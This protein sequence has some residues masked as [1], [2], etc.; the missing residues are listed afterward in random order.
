MPEQTPSPRPG[1]GCEPGQPQAQPDA[2]TVKRL[3]TWTTQYFTTAGLATPRLDAEVLLAHVLRR[4]RLAL[5]LDYDAPVPEDARRAYRALI[6]RRRESEPVAY[7]TGTR[8]FFSLPFVVNRSVLIPRPE[9]EHLVELAL[10]FLRRPYT[11]ESPT[12]QRI[13]EIGTG[14]GNIALTLAHHLPEAWVVSVDICPEA[15]AVARRNIHGAPGV[16]ER[17]SLVRGDLTSW[18]RQG[19]SGF[20]LIV[21]N[22][23]YVSS[24]A[25]ERLS[26][27]V[28]DHEPRAAL[29]GGP[30]GTEIQERIL[31]TALPFLRPNGL[32]LLEMGADQEAALRDRAEALEGYGTVQ[33]F[34]DFAGKPRVL[35]ACRALLP[36]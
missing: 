22:P 32:L 16:K 18:L 25:W 11:P 7:L 36:A 26:P 15:L 9:T 21:S 31:E 6:R 29:C 5:Y 1:G 34:P 20:H 24:H 35:A 30:R 2:W 4:D 13:L 14:C 33:V 23:P 17:V 19:C 8:E 27:D 28:R 10:R 3:L 12:P